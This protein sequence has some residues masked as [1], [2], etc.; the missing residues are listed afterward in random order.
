MRPAID[1]AHQRVFVAAEGIQVAAKVAEAPAQFVELPGIAQ[2]RADLLLVAD[3]PGRFQE[4]PGS[5]VRPRRDE[6]QVEVG[7]TA[8]D[9]RPPATNHLRPETS[10]EHR[11]GQ[12]F[13]DLIVVND[14][15]TAEGVPAFDDRPRVCDQ[16]RLRECAENE[17]SRLRQFAANQECAESAHS[18]ARSR[19][20]A[21][22][23]SPPVAADAHGPLRTYR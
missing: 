10:L 6:T 21:T 23:A 9:A 18:C 8:P 12:Q 13:E 16:Y 11:G 15:I 17:R 19:S 1:V 2:D 14:P 20:A 7:K 4:P 3:H 5:L 22:A